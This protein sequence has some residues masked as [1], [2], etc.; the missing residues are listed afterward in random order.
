[1]LKDIGA[2]GSTSCARTPQQNGISEK[3]NRTLLDL[4]R[5]CLLESGLHQKL[6]AESINFCNQ[7]LNVITTHKVENKSPFEIIYGRK[8]YLGH[9]QP[10]GSKCCILDQTPNKEKMEPRSI[11]GILVGL[12]DG[13][14]GYRVLIPGKIP[15]TGTVRVSN[16]VRFYRESPL[17]HT[18]QQKPSDNG[19]SNAGPDTERRNIHSE[20]SNSS[21]ASENVPEETQTPPNNGTGGANSSSPETEA[22]VE[23]TSQPGAA[24]QR[25]SERL[26]RQPVPRTGSQQ[27]QPSDE[28]QRA[29]NQQPRQNE[30]QQPSLTE[31]QSSASVEQPSNDDNQQPGSSRAIDN[32]PER[33][34]RRKP[35]GS[36]GGKQV[37]KRKYEGTRIQL[38]DRTKYGYHA[39]VAAPKSSEDESDDTP[40]TYEEAMNSPEKDQW[41]ESMKAEINS[42]HS[43]NVWELT[44]LPSGKRSLGNRW[45]FRKKRNS[46][47][48]VESYKSRLVL[49]GFLQKAGVDFNEL[50]SPVSK[51]ETIRTI[52]NIAAKEKLVAY[53]F[54]VV[55]AFLHAELTDKIIYMDQPKGF[56]DGTK[57][58]CK[59]KKSI[60]G[61]RQSNRMF[62]LKIKS[63]FLELG[64]VQS[65]ADYCVFYSNGASKIQVCLYVD[66]GICTGVTEEVILEFLDKLKETTPVG[67]DIYSEDNSEPVDITS[68]QELI[69]SIMYLAQGSRPDIAFG[70]SV[71]SRYMHCPT[72]NLFNH[73]KR[74]LKYLNAT[75]NYGIHYDGDKDGRFQYFCDSDYAACTKTR[76]ST[77]GIVIFSNGSP[78]YWASRKQPTVSLSTCESETIAAA[79]LA[80]VALWF[81]RLVSELGYSDIPIMQLDNQAALRLVKESQLSRRTRHMEVRHL[82]IQ[83]KIAEKKLDVT[84]VPSDKNLSDICTKPMNKPC[85]QRLRDLLGI[86]PIG[87]A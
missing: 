1:M 61:L 21:S 81:H 8:P 39:N 31:Q 82:F 50:Y 33:R 15:G 28:E 76:K 75:Q 78:L 36:R 62:H 18:P 6:W 58:V 74:V 19:D 54:D 72:K 52:L 3:T 55:S 22:S 46:A 49:K 7:I 29:T 47:G 66:D 25:L 83:E 30:Q 64:L 63:I 23:R 45:V 84:F 70:I 35:R 44:E 41:F 73:A 27:Q 20:D 42:M 53:Q 77:T 13:V 56:S 16:N 86:K 14:L 26:Q 11:D 43:L 10:F 67:K 37:Q 87:Q 80:K 2:E 48:E 32:S 57:K 51:F 17:R 69:G 71:L 34:S 12:N 24:D 5:T 65:T 60:Y 9:I 38:R 68:Y 40:Q 79:D 85:F 59:L 4:S